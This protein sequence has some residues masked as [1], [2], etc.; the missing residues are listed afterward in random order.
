MTGP[1]IACADVPERAA[2]RELPHRRPRCAERRDWSWARST[3]IVVA[4]VLITG[5]AFGSDEESAAE[6]VR[7]DLEPIERL[8]LDETDEAYI[9]HLTH[10]MFLLAFSESGTLAVLDRGGKRVLLFDRDG[11]LLRWAG[12]EGDGPGE[13]R[14]LWGVAWDSTDRIWITDNQRITVLDR[15]LAVDTTFRADEGVDYARRMAPVGGGM[16][17]A[18][19]RW[20]IEG[21]A[22]RRYDLAGRPGPVIFNVPPRDGEAYVQQEF[23]P[24]FHTAG[25]T[26]VVASSVSYPL[27]LCDP[28]G[29]LLDTFGARPPSIGEMTY[30]GAGAFAGGAQANAGEWQ[31]SFGTVS[32][33]WVV[34]DSLIVVEHTRRHP[35]AG[36]IPPWSLWVDVYDRWTLEKL[37]EDL[38]LPVPGFIVDVHDDLLWLVT[39]SPGTSE[40][41]GG[42][43]GLTGFRVVIEEGDPGSS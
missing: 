25:D 13:F 27:Y 38:P 36:G 33:I 15:E 12:R 5:C 35:E 8:F 39:Q 41:L 42:P 31:R 17:V 10:G 28:E 37:G 11:Q 18:E 20:P 6:R 19:N 34:H 2:P 43:W 29:N 3:W 40:P 23:R 32:S 16:L 7:V 4:C 24:R 14:D 30:P 22:L 21:P 1:M 9:S 26:V